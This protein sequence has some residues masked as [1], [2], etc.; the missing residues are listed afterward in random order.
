MNA[1][2]PIN[3]MP[4][5]THKVS[6]EWSR[7]TTLDIGASD[8]YRVTP[9]PRGKLASL[10]RADGSVCEFF[11]KDRLVASEA[12]NGKVL[13]D[14]A[15]KLGLPFA[16]LLFV[17]AEMHPS[18]G[19]DD[20]NV[21]QIATLKCSEDAAELG[22]FRKTSPMG[23][24]RAEAF[25]AQFKQSFSASVAHLIWF[26]NVLDV[27]AD[28]IIHMKEAQGIY[29]IDYSA[30]SPL[31]AH[32][33]YKEIAFNKKILRED[34]RGGDSVMIY[35]KSAAIDPGRVAHI[36]NREVFDRATF[37]QTMQAIQI[38]PEGTIAEAVDKAKCGIVKLFERDG[39]PV[40]RTDVQLD[41]YCAKFTGVLLKRRND[42]P[43]L[44][45]T[46]L[47]PRTYPLPS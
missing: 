46:I 6:L 31:V 36:R 30:N 7:A 13:G 43:V 45:N 12:I 14:L 41:D 21:V 47:G 9:V 20:K 32:P 17:K 19:P 11:L 18:A 23:Y 27:S 8:D 22:D 28:N 26:G 1:G 34:A 40:N 4:P 38:L 15:A 33:P 44:A 42:I 2:T 37:D 24:R 35:W 3:K 10:R 5:E 29:F 25:L 16:P 39:L